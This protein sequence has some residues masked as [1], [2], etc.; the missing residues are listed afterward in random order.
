MLLDMNPHPREPASC[1]G[2]CSHL[3]QYDKALTSNYGPIQHYNL[4]AGID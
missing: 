1:S 4:I 3:E 2:T